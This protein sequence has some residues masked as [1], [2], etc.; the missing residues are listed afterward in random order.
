MAKHASRLVWIAALGQTLYENL[1]PFW[2]FCEKTA[3][4]PDGIMLLHA[5]EMAVEKDIAME[6]FLAA[7]AAY[8]GE[9][10]P[11]MQAAAFDDED[12]AGFRELADR[13]F[14]NVLKEKAAVV[15]D[16]SATTWSFVPIHLMKLARSHRE[17]VRT[18]MYMQYVSH[19]MRQT[20]YALLPRDGA[21]VHDL[22]N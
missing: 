18:V 10:P 14:R 9:K 21:A 1:N 17:M 4:R 13:T 19:K 12:I 7:S 16:V 5:A 22:L 6:A 11:D 20:P 3:A 15:V 2:A 8:G